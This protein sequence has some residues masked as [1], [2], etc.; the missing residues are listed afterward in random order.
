MAGNLQF[1]A[2]I[3]LNG[4]SLREALLDPVAADPGSPAAGQVWFN[5]T[6]GVLRYYDGTTTIDLGA[7]VVDGGAFRG[8]HD[9]SGGGLPSDPASLAGDKWLVSVGG[10]IAGLGAVEPGDFLFALVDNPTVAADFAVVQGN[11]TL[12]ATGV[13]TC[14]SQTVN[15]V[16]STALTITSADLSDICAWK[17]YNSA[18]QEIFVC[19][20]R[21]SATTLDL[22][23]NQAL[24]GVLI[25]MVG[26]GA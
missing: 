5:S 11:I 13:A 2:D 9:A 10:T 24:T 3:D 17:T 15:L 23:S 6:D 14:E 7:N 21:T 8:T 4:N 16:A 12:P 1:F 19:A 22:T 26:P 20:E 25:T 18:G